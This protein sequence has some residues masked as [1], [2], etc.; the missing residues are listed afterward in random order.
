MP[1]ILC[2]WI[3]LCQMY[4]SFG[5]HWQVSESFDR[6]SDGGPAAIRLVACRLHLANRTP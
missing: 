4:L 5:A 6:S 1:A 3:C 2:N